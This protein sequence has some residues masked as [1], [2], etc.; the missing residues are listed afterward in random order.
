MAILG[1]VLVQYIENRDVFSDTAKIGFTNLP[2]DVD[3]GTHDIDLG[4]PPDYSPATQKIKV[5]ASHTPLAPLI[6]KFVPKEDA[7]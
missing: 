7:Q 4:Q 6:V 1:S 2:F 5:K 3:T